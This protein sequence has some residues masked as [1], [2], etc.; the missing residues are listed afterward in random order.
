[1]ARRADELDPH[2]AYTTNTDRTLVGPNAWNT[3]P[4]DGLQRVDDILNQRE[5]VLPRLFV[6]G[7]AVS[8][9]HSAVSTGRPGAV[10][11]CAAAAVHSR[12][13]IPRS[14]SP[15]ATLAARNDNAPNGQQRVDDILNAVHQYFHDCS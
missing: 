11:G 9:Q 10:A 4:P 13:E 3:G 15:M 8:Y 2:P 1:M 14:R 6:D 7:T 5:T 12:E